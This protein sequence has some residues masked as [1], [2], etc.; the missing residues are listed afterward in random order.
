MSTLK[1]VLAELFRDRIITVGTSSSSISLVGG[2]QI[3]DVP[4]AWIGHMT[5]Y[6][7]LYATIIGAATATVTFVYAILKIRRIVKNPR[8]A[9]E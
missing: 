8:A 7:G 9:V 3:A 2:S 4:P 6:I 5:A 1:L